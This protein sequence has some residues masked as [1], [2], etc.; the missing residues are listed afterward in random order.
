MTTYIIFRIGD[1]LFSISSQYVI[2]IGEM[3]KLTVVPKT[4][5]YVKGMVNFM[6]DPILV[7][8]PHLLFKIDVKE[9]ENPCI[10][11]L[12]IPIEGR[13]KRIGFMIDEIKSAI[14]IDENEIIT[15]NKYISK[16]ISGI[17]NNGDD[18]IFM[19]DVNNI[20]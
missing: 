16:F 5:Y 15:D 11:I 20:I 18:L 4:P 12:D 19:L 6:G 2:N 10:L 17:Y 1:E 14:E 8:D 13:T 7:V 9:S 3:M